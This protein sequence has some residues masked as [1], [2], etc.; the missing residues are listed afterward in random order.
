MASVAV[1]VLV[2]TAWCVVG[3]LALSWPS[4]CLVPAILLF[5]LLWHRL[6]DVDGRRRGWSWMVVAAGTITLLL[7]VVDDHRR[8]HLWMEGIGWVLIA[9]GLLLR[10]SSCDGGGG[11]HDD[12]GGR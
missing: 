3:C 1:A 8:Q 7:L 11:V 10:W 4:L 12:A 6:P 9:F 2:I 5:L